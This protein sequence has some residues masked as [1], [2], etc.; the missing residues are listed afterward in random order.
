MERNFMSI[1]IKGLTVAVLMAL[2]TSANAAIEN[3]TTG[4][5]ELWLAAWSDTAKKAYSFDTGLHLDDFAVGNAGN[6]NHSFNFASDSSWQQ[7]S[8]AISAGDVRWMVAAGDSTGTTPGS[9]RWVAT[10]STV[11]TGQVS[12]NLIQFKGSDN[13]LNA[14]NFFGNHLAQANGSAVTTD[15]DGFAWPGT[16]LLN[17]FGAKST[18]W[19]AD[20]ALG[21]SSAFY[22][23]ANGATQ[24]TKVN[25]TPYAG[26]WSLASN[27]TLNYSASAVPVPAAVWLLGSALVG[28]V[29][30]AR[31]QRAA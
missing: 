8:S 19:A 26:T 15:Q 4:N 10:S 22:F 30:V 24:L 9:N 2:G 12:S 23:L 20:I 29:G 5:G 21:D 17:T 27:G 1:K 3:A 25:G 28:M 16:S 6:L 11:P 13:Y 14:V 7:F 18:G 31:R